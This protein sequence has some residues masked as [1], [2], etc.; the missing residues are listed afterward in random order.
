M[1]ITGS[2]AAFAVLIGTT[3]QSSAKAAA[4]LQGIR[5]AIGRSRSDVP[6]PSRS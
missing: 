1:L 3:A 2:V 4:G 5:Q 6:D